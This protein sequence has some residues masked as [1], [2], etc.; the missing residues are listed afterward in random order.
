MFPP[1]IQSLAHDAV[2]ELTARDLTLATAESCTGG[3]IAA[4]LTEVPGASRVFRFGW[5]TYSQAAKMQE[6]CVP[7]EI[8]AQHTVV[9]EAV[10][11]AMASAA[12]EKASA[13]FAL[14]VSGNAGPTAAEGEPPVGT[15]CLALATPSGTLARTIFRPALSR[16]DFRMMVVHEA[17]RLFL[18]QL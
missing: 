11:C 12:R 2:A 3:L 8:I 5:V 14:A 15:V 7:Q 13:D 16:H 9:S 6:L 4:A 18:A 10:V 1:D 17:L